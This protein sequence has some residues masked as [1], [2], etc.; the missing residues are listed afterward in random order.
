MS[1]LGIPFLIAGAI[2]VCGNWFYILR[3]F[4]SGA[5]SSPIPILGSGLLC[6]G[7][8]MSGWPAW[9]ILVINLV[10][11]GGFGV[12][13]IVLLYTSLLRAHSWLKEQRDRPS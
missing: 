1:I 5:T 11:P 3:Y 12:V 9:S 4:L 6:V 10:D 13:S 8:V 2:I 7:A